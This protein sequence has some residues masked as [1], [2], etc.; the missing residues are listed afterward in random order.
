MLIMG[1]GLIL[2][3]QDFIQVA[4]SMRIGIDVYK[5]QQPYLHLGKSCD[6]VVNGEVIGSFGEVHPVVQENFE[7]DQV[8]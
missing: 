1:R 6:I 8:T 4:K 5:R 7:L 2:Q 3:Q